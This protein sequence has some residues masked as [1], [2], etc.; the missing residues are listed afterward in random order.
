MAAEAI[1]AEATKRG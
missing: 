1:Q